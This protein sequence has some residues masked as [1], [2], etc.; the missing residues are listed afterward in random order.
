MLTPGEASKL[1]VALCLGKTHRRKSKPTSE[2]IKV[3]EK[4]F[5]RSKFVAGLLASGVDLPKGRAIT[6][7]NINKPEMADYCLAVTYGLLMSEKV[8]IDVEAEVVSV[9]AIPK[10]KD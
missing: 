3:A 10:D 8:W 4:W 7:E 1:L 9:I 5:D 2:E 6:P